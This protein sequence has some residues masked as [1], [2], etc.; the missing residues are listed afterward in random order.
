MTTK[1]KVIKKWC[2]EMKTPLIRNK[3]NH[4]FIL[5]NNNIIFKNK[6]VIQFYIIYYTHTSL[7]Y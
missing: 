4:Y 7:H 2:E 5:N 6:N 1:H 3:E